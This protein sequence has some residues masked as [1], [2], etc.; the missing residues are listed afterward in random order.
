MLIEAAINGSR[1]KSE[2]PGVPETPSE[3][4]HAALECADAGAGAIHF[5][6]RSSDG[7]ETLDPEAL[8]VCLAAVRSHVPNVPVGVSTGAWIVPDPEKRLEMIT[9]WRINLDFASVNFHEAGATLVA[10]YLLDRGIGVEAGLANP[11]AAEA[12]IDSG[13]ASRALR[14]LIEPQEQD[15]QA[16]LETVQNIRK[17]LASARLDLPLVLHG[18]ENTTWR[19]LDEAI[20]CGHDIRI[21]FE[22]TLRLVDGQTAR[23]NG[24]LVRQ[25][26][27]R[28]ESLLLT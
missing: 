22:D 20:R 23:S 3:I 27:R 16:A 17:V 10:K 13:M 7:R 24:T 11:Q 6:V 28:V 9:G 18:T 14:I 12:Y 26:Q 21:G 15:L 4:A 8:N 19:L 25:A 2:H 1:R 5:H